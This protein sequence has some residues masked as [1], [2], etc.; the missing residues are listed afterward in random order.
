[1]KDF[2][3]LADYGNTKAVAVIFLNRSCPNSRLYENRL[4][5]LATNYAAK[6]V[7]FLFINPAISMEEGSSNAAA[8]NANLKLLPDNGQKISQQFGATKTPEAF[9]LQNVN[10]S[11]VL[12]YKGAID[13]NP[14][15]ESSVKEPYLRNA[16][17]AV[18]ANQAVPVPEKRALGCMIK[19]F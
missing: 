19:R 14:Q 13:D 10:G 7:T 2:T 9:V 3:M 8:G 17:D 5:Q 12:K 6:G 11:F 1:V 15:L 18:L 16:L 4:S